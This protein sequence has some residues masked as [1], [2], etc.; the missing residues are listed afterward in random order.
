MQAVYV[1]DAPDNLASTY[2]DFTLQHNGQQYYFDNGTQGTYNVRYPDVVDVSGSSASAFPLG[3]YSPFPAKYSG[4]ALSGSLVYLAVPFET[5]YPESARQELF[6][7]VVQQLFVI[8]T[9]EDTEDGLILVYPNPSSGVVNVR[10]PFDDLSA[11]EFILTD[12]SGR[13]IPFFSDRV[14][15]SLYRLEIK[16]KG[17]FILTVK[18]SKR[19]MSVAVIVTGVRE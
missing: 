18:Q 9:A 5:I 17:F 7:W 8:E 4:V 11:G 12:M 3:Y 2:Y 13:S 15:D 10:V 14:Y 16:Q 1:E 19:I 6:D